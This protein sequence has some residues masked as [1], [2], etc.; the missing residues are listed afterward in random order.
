MS[1]LS[2]QVQEILKA[3]G[4]EITNE[5]LSLFELEVNS[6]L[7]AVLYH[8]SNDFSIYKNE[9][10][11]IIYPYAVSKFIA[12]VIEYYER[13]EVKKGLKARSMGTVSYTFKD[14]DGYIPDYILGILEPFKLRKK[15]K[16]H[17]FK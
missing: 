3:N 13:P 9:E 7:D 2:T 14:N 1:Q 15:A 12:S 5:Q 11:V 4:I 6:L 10:G 8:T 17:V 16:F